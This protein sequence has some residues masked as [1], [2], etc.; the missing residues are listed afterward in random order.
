MIAGRVAAH[1]QNTVTVAEIDPVI[2][3]CTASKRLCQSRYSCAV[4]YPG[5][6]LDVDETQAPE[7]FLI[8]ETLFIV[9][10]SAADRG[11]G[12]GAVDGF[13]LGIGSLE[14]FIAALF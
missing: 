3:H 6:V 14:A 10:G 9:H 5:L 4:S 8:D 2:G 13:T 12:L 7:E 1:Y 11:N